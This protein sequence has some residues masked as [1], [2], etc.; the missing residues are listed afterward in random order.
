M[1]NLEYLRDQ[2]LAPANESES[3]TLESG[4]DEE[5]IK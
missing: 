5:P 1:R 3:I 4:A 2:V